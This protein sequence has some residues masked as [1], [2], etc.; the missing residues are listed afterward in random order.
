VLNLLFSFSFLQLP[1]RHG[2]CS[3]SRR[4]RFGLPFRCWTL[5]LLCVPRSSLSLEVLLFP[6][7]IVQWFVPI[8]SISLYSSPAGIFLCSSFSS[9]LP[10][11]SFPLPSPV[12]GLWSGMASFLS[13]AAQIVLGMMV[14][15]PSAWQITVAMIVLQAITLAISIF[16]RKVLPYLSTGGRESRLT[17]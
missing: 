11:F 2:N 7:G 5:S 13:I 10:P 17:F 4:T 8:P 12:A 9:P 15:E 16:G 14:A 3:K 1:F 6:R